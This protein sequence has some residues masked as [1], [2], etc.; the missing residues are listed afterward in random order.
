MAIMV[1]IETKVFLTLFAK[2]ARKIVME[3]IT[4][5][6][7]PE[8]RKIG[9]LLILVVLGLLFQPLR[10]CMSLVVT[11]PPII[12]DGTWETMTTVGGEFYSPL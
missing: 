6:P 9:G 2:I 1:T 4:L 12:I 11:F 5:A 7:K 3:N 10:L 8:P